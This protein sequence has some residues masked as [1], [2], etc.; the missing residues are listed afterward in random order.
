V[1]VDLSREKPPAPVTCDVCVV[2]SG[3]GGATAARLLAEAGRDVVVLEEGADR[4][5]AELT[6]RDGEMYDQLYMDRGGR[7]TDDLAV[8]VL[9]GRALGGGAV[10]NACDVVPIP[11]GVLAHWRAKFG[12]A[13]LTPEA[14]APHLEAALADLSANP[15]GEHQLNAANRL[16]RRGAEALGLRGEVMRHNRV[17][18]AGLGT[19]LIGCPANAK[20][21]P[22]FVAIPAAIAAGARFFLRARAVRIE[23]GGAEIKRVRVR[24]LDERGYHERGEWEVRA[25]TVVVAANAVATPQLLRRS[26]LGNEHVGRHLMLQPQLPVTAL[27]DERVDAFRGI[28]QAYAITAAELEDDPDHGLWGFRIEA[29]MG[30]PGISA[31]L[32]PA[33]GAEGKRLMSRYAH[34]ASSLLLVPDA[35]SGE[36]DLWKDGRPRI[37]Y[38]QRG[39]HKA[40]LREAVRMAA[41]VYFAAG[42]R[43][44]WVPVGAGLVLR[45][46]DDLDAVDGLD[47]APARAPLISAHQQGTVRM[48]PSA[49]DGAAD[50][51]GRLYGARGVY[52]FD[53]SLFPSSASSHTMT[54]ILTMA[55]WL[56]SRL[57]A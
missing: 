14:L 10:V 5:G 39:D 47:F 52:V 55:R 38:R 16:L 42:A 7:A 48:A 40:R 26:G 46:G 43:E 22:R 8:S 11:D 33:G 13:D 30:T 31:S 4:T 49:R 36:V 1:I 17:G 23:D 35:P 34:M 2:G 45:P 12:L 21:N 25:R 37:R 19:C 41:R 44:V 32:L 28:P 24:T 51:D 56:G 53:S 50:P 57:A 3:P 15:I 29:I 54:P 6:Q 9:Q 18:C 27:F 20:R